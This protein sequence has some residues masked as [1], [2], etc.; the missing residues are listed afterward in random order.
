MTWDD[1]YNLTVKM[2]RQD[3]GQQFKGIVFG[4]ASVI[5]QNQQ[6]VSFFDA[7]GQKAVFTNDRFAD[8]FR[9]IARFYKIPGME[10]PGHKYK[11]QENEFIKDQKVAMLIDTGGWLLRTA[12]T[13]RSQ[14]R[15]AAFQVLAYMTSD[16]YQEWMVANLGF[17]PVLKNTGKVMENFGKSLPT[18]KGKN[19]KALIPNSFAPMAV[20]SEFTSIA[21]A[22]M[23]NTLS[24]YS[25]GTD[26]NTA[27]REAEER[28]NKKIAQKISK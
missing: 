17:T 4:L 1:L 5:R 22:E 23:N 9:N 28:A 25:A 15:D 27:L 6:S 3:G 12:E 11:A 7:S 21:N 8:V 26:I 10:L 13:S 19:V 20:P 24:A 16:E 2:T 18:A 14:N